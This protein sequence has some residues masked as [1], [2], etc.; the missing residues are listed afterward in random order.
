M[1]KKENKNSIA[2]RS[3]SQ[4]C[5]QCRL[6]L[7]RAFAKTLFKCKTGYLFSAKHQL[8]QVNRYICVSKWE[9]KNIRKMFRMWGKIYSHISHDNH[10]TKCCVTHSLF[11]HWYIT[12]VKNCLQWSFVH[13]WVKGQRSTCPGNVPKYKYH[14]SRSS[15]GLLSHLW[16]ID[17]S[18]WLP[19]FSGDQNGTRKMQSQTTI[20][21]I[22]TTQGQVSVSLAYWD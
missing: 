11:T 3:S 7:K 15:T 21:L 5:V 4:S 22:W 9:K 20:Q 16:P 19:I 13:I 18:I 17:G 2:G 14:E 6:G 1:I 10:L 12:W 8:L